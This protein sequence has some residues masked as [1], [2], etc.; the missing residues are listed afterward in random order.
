[1]EDTVSDEISSHF[2]VLLPVGSARYLSAT[3]L[4]LLE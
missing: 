4:D 2:A 1:M 3:V